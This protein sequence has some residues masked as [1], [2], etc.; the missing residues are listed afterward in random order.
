MSAV[1]IAGSVALVTG[2]QRG[3][4]KAFTQELLSRGAAKIYVTARTPKESDDPRIVP[5]ALEV[6]DTGAITALAEKLTDVT[7]VINNAGAGGG[8]PLL[9]ANLA[10]VK[11]L[12][13]INVFGPLEVAKAFAP[14]LK[15]NG[16]GALVDIH[17]ALSWASGAGAYGA[18]KAALWSITNTLRLDLANQN[19]LVVGVHLGFA[20][21]D[22]TKSVT[23]P[24][25]APS[26][27][28]IALADA[29][30]AGEIEV[31]VDDTSRHFKS[32]LSG[33]VERLST[34]G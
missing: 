24:K 27:A 2:G 6:T 28:A 18:T 9:E 20:D 19:T 1:S 13:D 4:G 16:G 3:L 17:S 23:A 22:L 14:I 29:L 10:D 31:L 25:I 26:Q 12:F 21:T 11:R 30:E 33:P 34:R 8:A 15:E 32:V 5:V 7:I